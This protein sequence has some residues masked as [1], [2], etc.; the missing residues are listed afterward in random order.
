MSDPSGDLRDRI[1]R[2]LAEHT[3]ANDECVAKLWNGGA[4][5]GHWR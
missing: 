2:T 4:G 1:A 5:A 3:L